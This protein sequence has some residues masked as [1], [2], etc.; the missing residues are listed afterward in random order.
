MIFASIQI[1]AVV[2]T[3]VVM[4]AVEKRGERRRRERADLESLGKAIDLGDR[5]ATC[6]ALIQYLMPAM[7][8]PFLRAMGRLSEKRCQIFVSMFNADEWEAE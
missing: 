3:V 8:R 1:V 7:A 4:R 6:A 5:D 2:V